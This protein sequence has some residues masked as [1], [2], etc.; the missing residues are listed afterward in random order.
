MKWDSSQNIRI[1][2][3][4][5]DEEDTKDE[6]VANKSVE[7]KVNHLEM[8]EE[9]YQVKLDENQS[10]KNLEP[11]DDGDNNRKPLAYYLYKNFC[12]CLIIMTVLFLLVAALATVLG[13]VLAALSKSLKIF[14]RVQVYSLYYF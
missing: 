5:A 11:K 8:S 12:P 9:K 3:A 14:Y 13:V 10:N 6:E 4:E 1:Q 7:E 2:V